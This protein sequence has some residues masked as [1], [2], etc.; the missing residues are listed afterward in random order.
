MK[1]LLVVL[2]GLMISTAFAQDI[3]AVQKEIDETLWRPF[4]KAFEKLDAKALNALY[5]DEVLRV[6]PGG[7]DTKEAFKAANVE[8][9]KENKAKNVA[10]KLDFWLDDRKTSTDTSYEVGFYRIQFISKEGVT[11]A[12]GQFHIVL[13]K[14]DGAWKITQDWDTDNINGKEIGAEDFGRQKAIRF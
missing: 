13:K 9:F 11:N 2:F 1:K 4:Q 7:I 10:I 6:T 5:A 3:A 14:I 8:R 12:H